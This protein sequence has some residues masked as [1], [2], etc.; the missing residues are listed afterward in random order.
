MQCINITE[1]LLYVFVRRE[2]FI[3]PSELVIYFSV[4]IYFFYHLN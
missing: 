3:M 2:A 4:F 1:F